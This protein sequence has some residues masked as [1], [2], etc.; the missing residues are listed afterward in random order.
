MITQQDSPLFPVA[1]CPYNLTQ[2][3]IPWHWHD[4]MEALL[5]T[6]GAA[7]VT[8]GTRQHRIREGEGAIINSGVLH[9]AW[10]AET[11]ENECW[12]HSIVFH[13]RLVGGNTDSIFWQNYLFP[14]TREAAPRYILLDRSAPWHLDGLYAME[15]AWHSYMHPTE[16]YEFRI[17]SA[18]SQLIIQLTSHL[19]QLPAEPPRKKALRDEARI[20]LMLQYIHSDYDTDITAKKIAEHA[21][22]SESECL[23]CFRCTIGM[24]PVQYVKWYRIQKAAQLLLSTDWKI[25]EISACCGF[26]DTSYFVKTFRELKGKTPGKYRKS[27]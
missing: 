1:C 11:N 12:L 6:D 14:L 8:I 25:A 2:E 20:K 13:P 15:S 4:E 22:I 16:G 3:A 24:P 27:S 10:R 7:D 26:Q 21:S 18:L 23:R 19:S 5:V 9:A 17:R